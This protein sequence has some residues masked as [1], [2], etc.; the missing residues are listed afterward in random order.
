M[1]IPMETARLKNK[2]TGEVISVFATTEHSASSYGRAVWVDANGN[3]YCEVDIKPWQEEHLPYEI[4]PD[5][6]EVKRV[7]GRDIQACREAKGWSREKL[8]RELT[9]LTGKA[10]RG[11]HIANIEKGEKSY[12]I[13]LLINIYFLLA[14]I[15]VKGFGSFEG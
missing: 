7:V 14:P 10:I 9:M 4:F 2:T 1:T 12:M 15:K 8:A 5:V 6:S 13:D 3:A 11:S